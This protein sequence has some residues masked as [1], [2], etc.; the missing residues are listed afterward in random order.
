MFKYILL[1]TFSLQLYALQLQIDTAR[2]SSQFYSILHITDTKSFI[3]EREPSAT[4]A[5]SEAICAFMDKP[6]HIF[7]N[8][9]NNYFNVISTIK[10][11]MFFVI[12]QPKYKM[13]M[14]PISF[15]LTIDQTVF[16]ADV[17]TAK[18]WLVIGYKNTLPLIGEKTYHAL[19][20][21]VTFSNMTP[22]Y[23]GGLDLDGKPIHIRQLKNIKYYISIKKAYSDKKYDKALSLINEAMQKYPYSI[24]GSLYM[25]DKIKILYKMKE[26]GQ[27]LKASEQFLR[28]YSGNHH[29]AEVLL[30]TANS[31]QI[32]KKTAQA[33]YFYNR[34]LSEHENSK[35]AKLGLIKIGDILLADDKKQQAVDKYVEALDTTHNLDVASL[36]AYKIALFS[37]QDKLLPSAIKYTKKIL[38]ANPSFFAHN[39]SKAAHISQ[40]FAKDKQY[41]LALKITNIAI[42]ATKPS[43]TV[44]PLLLKNQG[45]WT[46][47]IGDINKVEK[48]FNRYIK[49][50]PDSKYIDTVKE[51]K[52]ALFFNDNNLTVAQRLKHYDYLIKKYKDKSIA[53]TALKKKVNLL[54]KTKQ[55]AQILSLNLKGY[56]GIIA[57][58][59]KRLMR[60]MIAKNNCFKAVGLYKKYNLNIN[61]KLAENLYQCAIQT[62]SYKTAHKIAKEFVSS[63]DIKKRIKWMYYDA[64]SLYH[65][66]HYHQVLQ[67]GSDLTVL[68]Q[69]NNKSPYNKIYRVM[70]DTYAKL[71]NHEK[72]LS[73]INKII[74]I[75]SVN[76]NDISRYIK[77]VRLGM[78]LKDNNIITVYGQYVYELQNRYKTYPYSPYIEFT[79]A[80]AYINNNHIHKAVGVLE[81][82]SNRQLSN[83]QKSKQQYLL[84]TLFE[85][86][87]KN[88]QAKKAFEASVK[89]DKSSPWAQLSKDAMK[90]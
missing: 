55:Y 54:F 31:D 23:V 35:Y 67:I 68:L 4:I 34:L 75:F 63:K 58:S 83:T 8:I 88:K 19:N 42:G 7:K 41:K 38:N 15:N 49:D 86:E 12:I 60:E 82:L 87:W 30:L 79:L 52:Y 77:L 44:Y 32:L 78:S 62:L 26:Y 14:R 3:C 18:K 90:F 73:T 45:I 1:I 21:P 61:N 74:K 29:T 20:L 48:L 36:A 85:Q 65:L 2:Q 28:K 51:A 43:E 76:F 89:A 47:K 11:N 64:V 22:A 5:S 50:F 46:A 17:K 57:K 56:D 6:K 70:F 24:F 72:M 9:S 66:K 53:K 13:Y 71:H 10:D 37:M 27:L 40:L 80:Q 81:S 25:Y 39:P 33:K 16:N 84:G 59:A 69:N